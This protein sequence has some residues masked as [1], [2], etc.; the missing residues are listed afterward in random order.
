MTP[1]EESWL[2][3]LHKGDVME[4]TLVRESSSE[5]S[6]TAV[7]AWLFAF[8]AYSLDLMDW[9]FLTFTISLISKEF[10]FSQTQMGLLLGSPL[11][12]A[13]VGGIFS[14]WLSDKVGRVK[15][16][17]FTLCWFSLFTIL[18]PFGQNYWAI[19]CSSS[20]CRA[21]PG[22]TVGSWWNA[23]CRE[24]V[25]TK[26]R[27]LASSTIQG[28]AAMGP[29]VAAFATALVVPTYGWRP[30]FFIGAF[31]LIVALCL[32][33]FIPETELWLK[34]KEKADKGEIKLANFRRLL[35]S[36]VFW[37]IWLRALPSLY[38]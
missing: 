28:A 1:Y 35:K 8:L 33:I 21:W 14:G 25:P 17:V 38:C 10:N 5:L 30:V 18:F 12:G 15:A 16:M 2:S 26:F 11:I 13:G 37:E 32:W 4:V 20:S 19:V 23:R 6:K 7:Y 34:T 36:R 24:M 9:N 29:M 27:I 31:G 22:C 3:N